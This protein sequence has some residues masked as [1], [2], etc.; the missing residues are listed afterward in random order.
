MEL[1][2]PTVQVKP[3]FSPL[4]GF[5]NQHMALFMFDGEDLPGKSAIDIQTKKV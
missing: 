5:I 3:L 2:G 1:I 4:T